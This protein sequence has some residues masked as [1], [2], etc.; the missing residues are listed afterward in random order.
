MEYVLSANP[1]KP[2]L[3]RLAAAG[4]KT[5]FV[6][7]KVLPEWWEDDIAQNPAGYQQAVT[8]LSRNLSLDARS[9]QEEGGEIRRRALK[10]PKYKLKP[11]DTPE[12]V[13][14]AAC[15]AFRAAQLACR[16]MPE[17]PANPAASAIEI[18]SALLGNG[19]AC[20]GFEALLDYCWRSGIP[21]L[22]VSAFPAGAHRPD[23]LAAMVDGRH[24]IV[25]CKQTRY[26]AWLLFHLA[27]EL[28]H[29]ALG[30]L[31]GGDILVDEEVKGDTDA[32]EAEANTFAVELL[33]GHKTRSYNYGSVN[34]A[35][36][37]NIV[38][39]VGCDTEVSPGFIALGHARATGNW[40]TANAALRIIRTRLRRD[41]NSPRPP[42]E[43]PRYRASLPRQ[44]R[45]SDQNH[46]RR[47]KRVICFADTDI[48]L[49][50]LAFGLLR[51][52]LSILG[53]TSDK[54]IHV[55]PE[56]AAKCRHSRRIRADFRQEILTQ[57]LDF[58][59]RT[60]VIT[61]P[62]DPEERE[63]LRDLDEDGID[64]GE[65]S[66]FLATK[67]TDDFILLTGDKLAL[68][69]LTNH[70]LGADLHNRL[71]GRVHCLET[72]LLLII[73]THGYN[74][75]YPKLM[76]GRHCDRAVRNAFNEGAASEAQFVTALEQLAYT[77]DFDTQ[78]LLR[79]P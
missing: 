15:I 9:L 31:Q 78:G 27:H 55:T 41:R 63:Q 62:G 14:A 51:Q 1:M 10:H 65:A 4:Y 64:A 68:R 46:W 33:T 37:A 6:R 73:K 44:R 60:T 28:G 20:I 19:P 77:L 47:R 21:V 67:D 13:Q 29:I 16:A 12:Q 34:A 59:K 5:A 50:L 74:A 71:L 66:L 7:R 76:E 30:H 48:L 2:L 54:D 38:Q 52:A 3:R 45:F 79:K 57:A 23:A 42:A 11:T 8:L 53:M 69:T 49:K 40:A 36:L 58:L 75:L 70:F 22:H 61:T 43:K 39:A 24:A 72:I 25:L 18:R 56:A 17:P 26:P 35:Q 32:E